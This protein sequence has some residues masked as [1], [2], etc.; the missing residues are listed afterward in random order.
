MGDE[1]AMPAMTVAQL[2]K[3]LEGCGPRGDESVVVI[4]RETVAAGIGA[5][6][7]IDITGAH[8]GFD[9]DDGVLFLMPSVP[10]AATGVEFDRERERN[11]AL[12]ERLGWIHY[13]LGTGVPAETKLAEIKRIA[14][15][16][17]LPHDLP[18][19]GKSDMSW[20]DRDVAAH[21]GNGNGAAYRAGMSSAAAIC[22]M[23]AKEIEAEGTVGRRIKRAAAEIAGAVRACGDRIWDYR[24]KVEAD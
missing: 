1:T 2:R 23:V 3:C 6:S 13:V 20:F 7:S 4:P 12:T 14:L 24:A 18:K 21:V 8:F 9:W 10:V 22:D 11:R 5:T 17:G 16:H 15:G 19:G